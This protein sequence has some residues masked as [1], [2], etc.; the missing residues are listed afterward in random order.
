MRSHHVRC[1]ASRSVG[2]PIR[3]IASAYG[4]S[5]TAGGKPTPESQR[6]ERQ[7]DR[8][9]TEANRTQGFVLNEGGL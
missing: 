7:A 9:P 3:L 2:V 5:W 1:F 4:V 6:D 8:Y